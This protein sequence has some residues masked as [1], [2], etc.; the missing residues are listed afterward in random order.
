MIYPKENYKDF[1]RFT[2]LICSGLIFAILYEAYFGY[3][4]LVKLIGIICLP[5]PLVFIA[6]IFVTIEELLEN[7]KE[8][9]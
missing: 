8:D 2:L 6:W 4:I 1:S 3:S 7:K 9:K 5:A